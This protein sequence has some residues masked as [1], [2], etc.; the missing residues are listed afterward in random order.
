MLATSQALQGRPPF[1][2]NSR[3][4]WSDLK[5]MSLRWAHV[6]IGHVIVAFSVLFCIVA[7][8]AVFFSIFFP[9]TGNFVRLSC[10]AFCLAAII[11]S[12]SRFWT[13]WHKTTT[14]STL[15]YSLYRWLSTLS[16]RTGSDGSI[17][18]THDWTCSELLP[19]FVR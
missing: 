10:T 13:H 19:I 12:I 18:E 14:T 17:I 9:T 16:S 5:P 3:D 7:S 2:T 8:Y 1:V 4:L 15:L 6:N 11:Q